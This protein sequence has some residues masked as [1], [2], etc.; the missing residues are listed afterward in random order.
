MLGSTFWISIHW[1]WFL[2][3][4]YQLSLLLKNHLQSV[5]DARS[6]SRVLSCVLQEELVPV[7]GPEVGVG[8]ELGIRTIGTML[9]RGRVERKRRAESS[10]TRLGVLWWPDRVRIF[11]SHIIQ[12]ISNLLQ[13]AI[14]WQHVQLVRQYL[15]GGVGTGGTR[16]WGSG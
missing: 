9:W 8:Q 16:D 7:A 14:T 10:L 12:V 5:W 6:Q 1:C 2:L 4:F 13:K 15:G 11:S 3:N